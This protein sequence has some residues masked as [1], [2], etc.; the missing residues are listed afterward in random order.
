VSPGIVNFSWGKGKT[1]RG[2]RKGLKKKKLVGLILQ[3]PKERPVKKGGLKTG[4]KCAE[5]FEIK[6][7]KK[8]RVRQ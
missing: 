7:K 1:E 2:K 6:K 4:E 3:R 5:K 8:T